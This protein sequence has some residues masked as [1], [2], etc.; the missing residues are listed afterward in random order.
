MK[1]NREITYLDTF[2]EGGHSYQ[3]YLEWC[4]EYE[5]GADVEGG[6]DYWRWVHDEIAVDVEEFFTNLKFSESNGPCVVSGRLDMWWGHPAIEPKKFNSLTDAVRACWDDADAVQVW[7]KNGVVFVK[8]MHHD[9][10]NYF[11]IRPLTDR[12]VWMMNNGERV[13]LGN[14]WHTG[15]YPEYLY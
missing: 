1:K 8:A 5:V 2:C 12:G 4:D 14:H 11:E 10:T 3:D 15:K 7:T 13:C 9:G 6:E